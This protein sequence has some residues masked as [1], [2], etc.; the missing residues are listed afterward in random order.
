MMKPQKMNEVG[1]TS[2]GCGQRV[3]HNSE[4]WERSVL[5]PHTVLIPASPS[6]QGLDSSAKTS[7]A[8]HGTHLH[9]ATNLLV[10]R[11]VR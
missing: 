11:Q 4:H 10:T 6:F 9:R 7:G 1:K 2:H 5:I 8:L 3:F